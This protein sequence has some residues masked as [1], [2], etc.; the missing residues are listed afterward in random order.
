MP[1]QESS[2]S[3][4]KTKGTKLPSDSTYQVT[5]NEWLPIGKF[6]TH[7]CCDC[8]LA[9]KIKYRVHDGIM[10]EQWSRD[11]KETVRQRKP[12]GAKRK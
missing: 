10:E 3:R 11:E 2:P 4:L 12:N 8:G 1:A 5:D 7:V 6:K 9:H